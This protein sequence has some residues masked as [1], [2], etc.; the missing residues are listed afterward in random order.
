MSGYL[1]EKKCLSKKHEN[2]HT[3][4]MFFKLQGPQLCSNTVRKGD[5]NKENK[6]ASKSLVPNDGSQ[7]Y[8]ILECLKRNTEY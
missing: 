5:C 3:L 7:K 1:K 2:K 8:Q 4:K 6:T